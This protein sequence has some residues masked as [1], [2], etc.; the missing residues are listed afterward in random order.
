MVILDTE[1]HTF[2]DA[3]AFQ[4]GWRPLHLSMTCACGKCFCVHH[5]L[6]CSFGAFLPL[7]I[8]NCM[9]WQPTC[10][11]KVCSNVQIE[12]HLQPLSDE[13]L[14]HRTLSGDD[15]ARLDIS[16]RGFSILWQRVTSISH[17][18]LAIETLKMKKKRQYEE[19]VCN[20]EHG[21]LFIWKTPI[22]R[23]SVDFV[24]A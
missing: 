13:T 11:L 19:R 5:S 9:M 6:N 20:I 12:P 2:C 10:C 8:M 16:T 21:G 23:Q 4:Y 24:A 1:E 15:Q 18:S 17:F 3:I 7:G 22:T 14:S